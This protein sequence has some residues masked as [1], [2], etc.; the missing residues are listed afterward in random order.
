MSASSPGNQPALVI[1]VYTRGA[2]REQIGLLMLRIS[3]L[4]QEFF[5]S[6]VFW[7]ETF[8]SLTSHVKL[9]GNNLALT[10]RLPLA[11]LLAEEEKKKNL[12]QHI[13]HKGMT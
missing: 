4:L 8:Q 5:W 11:V 2:K 13:N 1:F 3:P 9:N 7:K 10:L 12:N 6:V